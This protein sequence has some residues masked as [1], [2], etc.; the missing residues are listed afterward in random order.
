MVKPTADFQGEARVTIDS[1]LPTVGLRGLWMSGAA[2][3]VAVLHASPADLVMMDLI[4][5]LRTTEGSGRVFLDDVAGRYDLAHP[6]STFARQLNVEW[7]T[8][9]AMVRNVGGSLWVLGL[10]TE[11]AGTIIET[12]AGGRT[13]VLG[14]LL[15]PVETVPPDLPAF[16]VIDAD[17]SL[18]ALAT[19]AY[20]QTSDYTIVVS[21]TAGG[22]TTTFAKP[23]FR[24]RG[25]G[26]HVDSYEGSPSQ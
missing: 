13:E 25:Y 8:T 14:G 4:G 7:V 10:K 1:T 5:D 11:R 20:T 9:P 26:M 17:F 3:H 12:S 23:Q 21:Q 18:M 16:R 2:G 19:T 22:V 15:Y 6:T 24:P